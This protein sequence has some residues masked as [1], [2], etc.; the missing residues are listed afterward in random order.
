MWVMTSHSW[1]GKAPHKNEKSRRDG[2]RVLSSLTG[3]GDL[4]RRKPTA[5][6]AG[7]FLGWRNHSAP[8][9]A[10]MA[11]IPLG[12]GTRGLRP[13]AQRRRRGIVVEHRPQND[14]APSGAA[15]SEDVAPDG[16][17][18]FFRCVSIE[19]SRL[20]RWR[21]SFLCFVDVVTKLLHR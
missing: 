20:R 12:F 9:L 19:M 2:R 3:L 4:G 11:G 18:I 10:L 16:A 13:A 21:R 7:Y 8:T 5:K 1:L 17:Q 15:Y 14:E 6:V